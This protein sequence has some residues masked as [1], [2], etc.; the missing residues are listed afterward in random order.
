MQMGR[1]CPL[2]A[3]PVPFVGMAQAISSVTFVFVVL[4][5]VTKMLGKVSITDPNL[6]LT[7]SLDFSFVFIILP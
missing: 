6:R 7:L 4:T 3:Y 1:D 2:M 5:I